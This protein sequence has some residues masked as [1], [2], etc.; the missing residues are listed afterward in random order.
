[1]QGK[2]IIMQIVKFSF[3]WTKWPAV[4]LLVESG[5]LKCVWFLSHLLLCLFELCQSGK[6]I[7][8]PLAVHQKPAALTHSSSEVNN[9]LCVLDAP[10]MPP[11]CVAMKTTVVFFP[12]LFARF[13]CSSWI[14]NKASGEINL[15]QYSASTWSGLVWKKMYFWFITLLQ[16]SYYN[17]I[18]R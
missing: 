2:S 1:M 12:E 13:I 8:G 9:L 16:I 3:P 6:E 17:V 18:M 7:C 14:G 4:F 5:F 11:V 15:V 10:L